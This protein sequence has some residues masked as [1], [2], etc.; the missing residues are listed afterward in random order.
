MCSQICKKRKT[1]VIVDI[2]VSKCHRFTG[3]D[4]LDNNYHIF[5]T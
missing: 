4:T 1:R 3:H 5:Q 2:R